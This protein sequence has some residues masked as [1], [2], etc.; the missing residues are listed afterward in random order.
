MRRKMILGLV[1][2][3]LLAVGPVST[4]LADSCTS[5]YPEESYA[6]NRNRSCWEGSYVCAG[7]ESVVI[8]YIKTCFGPDGPYDVFCGRVGPFHTGECCGGCTGIA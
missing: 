7:E 2:L 6:C 1:I 4:L 3:S 8:D 5:C